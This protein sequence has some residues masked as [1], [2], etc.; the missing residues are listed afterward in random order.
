M[1]G[2]NLQQLLAKFPR[3]EQTYYHGLNKRV[4]Y[5]EGVRLFAIQ[6]KAYWF[7][8]I[9]ATELA[10]L[11]QQQE[12]ALIVMTVAKEQAHIRVTD[13]NDG[14]PPVFQ[15]HITFTDCPAGTWRFYFIKDMIMLP[16]EY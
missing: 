2:E 11:R 5:T 10:I 6:A 16:S 15:R 7:L 8:D 14:S 13:G 1:S 4:N 9:L 3:G 12:F